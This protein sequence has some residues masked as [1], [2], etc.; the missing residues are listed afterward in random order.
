MTRAYRFWTEREI[1]ILRESYTELG[2][3][4]CAK[5]LPGRSPLRIQGA[6]CKLKI[7][8]PERQHRYRSAINSPEKDVQ[9]SE[10]YGVSVYRAYL[11]G[12]KKF[13]LVEERDLPKVLRHRWR[14]FKPRNTW[15]AYTSVKRDALYMHDLVMSREKGTEIDHRNRDGLDNVRQNLRKATRS[16]NIS[17]SGLRKN[18][19]SGYKGV[20]FLRRER[21]WV[22]A[23]GFNSRTIFLGHFET[24]LEAAKAYNR[25]AVK[26]HGEFAFLNKV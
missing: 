10:K 3:R 13:V 26:Y 17:N 8:D 19:T 21:K 25:A 12:N 22:A 20:C 9:A 14:A 6:A 2:P 15:Y 4:G 7:T 23:I 5:L 1:S 18:N 16:Q 11:V 24:A